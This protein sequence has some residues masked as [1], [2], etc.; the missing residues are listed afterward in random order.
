MAKGRVLERIEVVY[1]RGKKPKPVVLDDPAFGA[2]L[3]EQVV[4]KARTGRDQ[5]EPDRSAKPR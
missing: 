5:R 1:R 4:H 2:T 3:E